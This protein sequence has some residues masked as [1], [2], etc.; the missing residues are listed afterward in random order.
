M[1]VCIY[2]YICT[3]ARKYAILDVPVYGILSDAF[4]ETGVQKEEEAGKPV[5]IRNKSIIINI[6]KTSSNNKKILITKVIEFYSK[7]V[8]KYILCED[9]V[10]N[11]TFRS[12]I[13]VTAH[14]CF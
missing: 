11:E 14:Y 12:R 5:Y 2:I 6:A 9:I 4:P 7:A 10:E 3:T 13:H 8:L 1:C